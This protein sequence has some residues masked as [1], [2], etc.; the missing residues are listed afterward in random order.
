MGS[1]AKDRRSSACQITFNN[2]CFLYVV[3]KMWQRKK[4]SWNKCLQS[5]KSLNWSFLPSSNAPVSLLPLSSLTNVCSMPAL[6]FWSRFSPQQLGFL[7]AVLNHFKFCFICPH[8]LYPSLAS[9]SADL[10]LSSNMSPLVSDI[11]E[12]WNLQYWPLSARG[13]QLSPNMHPLPL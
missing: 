6:V 9:D 3:N 2:Q 4:I 10:L 5:W 11:P 8:S 1:A 13:C 12:S 7:T